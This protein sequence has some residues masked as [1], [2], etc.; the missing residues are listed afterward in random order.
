MLYVGAGVFV[1]ILAAFTAL[2]LAGKPTDDLFNL[3]ST[4]ATMVAAGGGVGALAYGRSASRSARTAAV[5]TNGSLDGRIRAGVKAELEAMLAPEK[6]ATA[7][8]FPDSAD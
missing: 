8:R 4:L 2:I 1:A 7:V 3:L 5:Q 6:P